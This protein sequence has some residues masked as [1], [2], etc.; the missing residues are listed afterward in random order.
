MTTFSNMHE[1]GA[2]FSAHGARRRKAAKSCSAVF[3]VLLLATGSIYH[4]INSP[5]C[6]KEEIFLLLTQ[7]DFFFLTEVIY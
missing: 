7:T 3:S 1:T 6:V 4:L 5:V 2:Q